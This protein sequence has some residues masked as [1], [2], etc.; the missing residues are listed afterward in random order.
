MLRAANLASHMVPRTV[1][2]MTQK[3]KKGEDKA[4]FRSLWS[5][6]KQA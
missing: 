3:N 2:G 1:Q 6:S 5:T 4:S